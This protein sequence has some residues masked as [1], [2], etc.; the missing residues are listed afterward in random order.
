M[1]CNNTWERVNWMDINEII[2]I[3]ESNGFAV[4]DRETP[5]EL[6]QALVENIDDGTIILE[7][8]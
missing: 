5:L 4:S 7:D 3:F 2:E 6:R 8:D 1:T